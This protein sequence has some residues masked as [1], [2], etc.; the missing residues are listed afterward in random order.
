M[1][2]GEVRSG[3]LFSYVECRVLIRCGRFWGLSMQRSLGWTATSSW[4]CASFAGRLQRNQQLSRVGNE[5]EAKAALDGGDLEQVDA[6][7][8]KVLAAEDVAAERRQLEA[9]ATS[10]Q[11]GEI[12]LT[13][14]RYRDAEEHFAAAA[15]RVPPGHDEQSLA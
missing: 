14:L 12:A 13:R 5:G 4:S 8:E 9:A 15:R 10:A 1:R 6:L 2:G 7:L 3:S 11:R